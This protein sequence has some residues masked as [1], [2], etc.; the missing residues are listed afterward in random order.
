MAE[1]LHPDTIKQIEQQLIQVNPKI[2]KGIPAEQKRSI[3]HAFMQVEQ[4][5]ELT[6]HSGPLPDP[7]TLEKYNAIIPNGAERIMAM[8]EK[9][10]EHRMGLEK[11]TI[12]EQLSQSKRGQIFGLII[13]LAAIT[14]SAICII[15]GH[16]WPGALLGAGGLTGL[17]S[18]FVYGK[19]QQRKSLAS[20][21]AR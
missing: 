2:F 16:E 11:S 6:H 7:Q 12:S 1:E 5:I 9:Q 19:N 3:V 18:V 13:G 15:L 17:V 20:K 4:K 10:Q 21:S 8:A 14:A